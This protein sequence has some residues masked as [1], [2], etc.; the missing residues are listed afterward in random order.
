VGYNGA[1]Q[2]NL[3]SYG[4]VN[5]AEI[6]PFGTGTTSVTVTGEVYFDSSGGGQ[7]TSTTGS[8]SS[9]VLFW[10]ANSATIPT[11]NGTGWT[12]IAG[13]NFSQSGNNDRWDFIVSGIAAGTDV[14]FYIRFND[15]TSGAPYYYLSKAG[16]ATVTPSVQDD[17]FKI[18]FN[19]SSTYNAKRVDGNNYDWQNNEKLGT[20]GGSANFYLTWNDTNLYILLSGGFADTDQLQIAIDTN[21][22]TNDVTGSSSTAAFSRA[23]FAGFL[24]PDYLIRSTGT[25]NLDKFVRSGTSWGSSSSIYS[26]ANLYRSGSVAEIRIP[27][28][29]I[30]SL[31][32]TSSFGV[33]FWLANSSGNLYSQYGTDNPT[34]CSSDCRMRTETGFT[35]SGS[36]IVPQSD[37]GVDHNSSETRTLSITNMRHFYVSNGTATAANSD[38]SVSGN[39]VIASGATLNLS[40]TSGNDLLIGGNWTNNGTFT[41][42]SREVEFNGSGAQTIN[43]ATTW[44]YLAINNIGSGVS[45]AANQ[46]VNTRL[47]FANGLLKLSSYNLTL[48]S[49]AQAVN[50]GPF[51]ASKMVVADGTGALCKQ[52]NA[53]GSYDYPIGDASGPLNTAEYSPATLN[54]TSGTF[55]SAQACV[56]VTNAKHSNN[57]S[58]TSYLT[59]YWTVTQSGISSF[60]CSTTFTY[61]DADITGTESDIYTGKWN[62]TNWARLD[63]ANASSNTIGGAATSFSDFTGGEYNPMAITLADFSAAQTGDAVL[64]TWETNSEL[65][66]RGFNLYRGL[67]PG[68]PDRQLNETLIPSQGPGSPG[69]FIYTWEDRADLVSGTTYFYWVED[70]DMNGVATRHGP[71]SVDYNAPTALRLLDAGAASARPLAL[72][73]MGGGLLALAAAVAWR[74]RRLS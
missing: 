57:T 61:V 19:G 25:T 56:R 6:R 39:V 62:G 47:R 31:A 36:G 7:S 51:S 3:T 70:V 74:K 52:Y 40:A 63:Q 14:M 27:R 60:S 5:D 46:T 37:Q 20:D 42:N 15:T 71:V 48:G 59:R 33:Y 73:L 29:E 66:N 45:L 43:S 18:R 16:G 44:D 64:L 34:S 67:S 53:T 65:D 10:A 2:I 38:T 58:T 9:A 12:Q 17:M 23:T 41:H 49:S 8:Q 11:I 4:V 30:G 54:F 21:P 55:N 72:P 32:T 13:S 50:G 68:A 22:G 28:S 26:S 1:G 69:G 35:S 24:T